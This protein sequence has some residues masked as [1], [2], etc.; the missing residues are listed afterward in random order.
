MS[1]LF[2]VLKE[3]TFLGDRRR[4]RDAS[5][6]SSQESFLSG[7]QNNHDV[8]G[9]YYDDHC[10]NKNKKR[11]M[12]TIITTREASCVIEQSPAAMQLR[13]LQTLNSI[14]SGSIQSVSYEQ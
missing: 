1:T 5:I 9:D 14:S 4:R 7:S 6:E 13:Y 2:K 10:A 11:L 12:I 3:L 8:D